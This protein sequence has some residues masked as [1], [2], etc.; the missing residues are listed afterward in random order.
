MPTAPTLAR[1]AVA[2]FSVA[3][4]TAALTFPKAVA[5]TSVKASLVL[6]PGDAR[7]PA[8]R[9]QR[10]PR[11]PRRERSDREHADASAR[12]AGTA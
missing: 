4:A 12:A 11:V 2:L 8:A 1:L 3:H 5:R 9:L 6:A 10:P 7:R